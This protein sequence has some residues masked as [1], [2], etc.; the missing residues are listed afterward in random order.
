[1][2]RRTLLATIGAGALGLGLVSGVAVAADRVDGDADLCTS[3]TCD[4]SSTAGQALGAGY[5]G[6]STAGQAA[7]PSGTEHANGATAGAARGGHGSAGSHGDDAG[8]EAGT[9]DHTLYASGELT[10]EQE[11]GLIFMVQ[12]EKLAFD[13]YTAFGEE[14]DVSTFER[15]ASSEAR[16][17]DAV[18]TLLATYGLVDPTIGLPAGEYVDAELAQMYD[19]LLAQGLVSVEDAFEVGQA[20]ELDDIE[21]LEEAAAGVTAPDV[22]HVYGQL[23]AGSEKHLSAFGG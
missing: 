7:T 10:A 5:R 18:R 8:V 1:M 16:H 13:L 17:M 20:V 21:E 2:K 23:L 22:V 12:E 4:G 6:G 9:G 19:D 15:I 3:S 11:A 14:Y